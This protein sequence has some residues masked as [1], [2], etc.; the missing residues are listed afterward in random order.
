LVIDLCPPILH[1]FG[2]PAALRWLG[3]QMQ[4]HELTVTVQID[5]DDL[6]LPED[7]ALL[8]FQS[9]RELLMNVVKHARSDTATVRLEQDSSAL[10]IEVQDQGIGF[11]PG[12]SGVHSDNPVSSSKFGLFSIRERM[13]S[14]GG[15]FE[16]HSASGNGTTAT[17]TL[18]FEGTEGP[19]RRPKATAQAISHQRS[20]ITSGSGDAAADV[21]H[22]SRPIRVLLV[23]DHAIVRQGMKSVLESYPDV[24]VVGEVFNGEE[25]VVA[26]K[27]LQPSHVVMD[28]NMPKM[29]G[30][31]AT[32][33]ITSRYPHIIVIGLSV[34]VTPAVAEMMRQ[35]GAARMLSKEGVV[36]EL[37]RAIRE[38]ME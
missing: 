36:N 19:G 23:D 6:S 34:N 17:L 13:I 38:T 4:R 8:L 20:V 32:A 18:P 26:A 2:L 9:V 15:R 28:V 29:N 7:R 21:K 27:A 31:E 14:L 12:A 35:A 37:Y 5:T 11:T 30:I 33:R 1:E 3:E 16:L 10:R 25:A 24:D 22:P